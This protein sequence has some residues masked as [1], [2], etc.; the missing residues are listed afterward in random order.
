MRNRIASS[1][2]SGLPRRRLGWLRLLMRKDSWSQAKPKARLGAVTAVTAVVSLVTALVGLATALAHTQGY[3][4][5]SQSPTGIQAPMTVTGSTSPPG[6]P[7]ADRQLYAG[8]PKSAAKNGLRLTV[9]RIYQRAGICY[10]DLSMQNSTSYPVAVPAIHLRFNGPAG[11]DPRGGDDRGSHWAGRVEPG[12]TIK[13]TIRIRYRVEPGTMP[14]SVS[15]IYLFIGP[16]A[17]VMALGVP[18]IPAI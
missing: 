14:M 2:T 13:G 6:D 11:D 5:P 7:N 1:P 8:P 3:N 18:N 17:P 9:S 12:K 4:N 10:I 15:F 16:D